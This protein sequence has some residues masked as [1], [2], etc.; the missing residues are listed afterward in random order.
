VGERLND[1]ENWEKGMSR[2][3]ERQMGEKRRQANKRAEKKDKD[4][5]GTAL[6]VHTH[7]SMRPLTL[8][9]LYPPS[10]FPA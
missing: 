4:I 6:F 10:A 1:K 9:C 5:K 3:K 7:P 8:P 2:E